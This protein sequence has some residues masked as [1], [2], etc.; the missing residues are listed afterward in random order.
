MTLTILNVREIMQIVAGFQHRIGMDGTVIAYHIVMIVAQTIISVAY[1]ALSFQTIQSV[2]RVQVTTLETIINSATDIVICCII[3]Y[4]I[5]TT[6]R[7]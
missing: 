1:L 4:I 2:A 3:C 7:V 6:S 5:S